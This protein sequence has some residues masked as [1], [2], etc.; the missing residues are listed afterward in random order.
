MP[1]EKPDRGGGD[2]SRSVPATN[3]GKTCHSDACMPAQLA[4]VWVLSCND[5]ICAHSPGLPLQATGQPSRVFVVER[6]GPDA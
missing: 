1:P 5:G 4:L 3:F 6:N 2:P